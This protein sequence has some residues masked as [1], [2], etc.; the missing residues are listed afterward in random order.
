MNASRKVDSERSTEMTQ[1][2]EL[3]DGVDERVIPC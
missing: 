3:E 2:K 1:G